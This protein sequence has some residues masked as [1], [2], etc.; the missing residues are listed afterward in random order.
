MPAMAL[1]V[2]VVASVGITCGSRQKAWWYYHQ[3]PTTRLTPLSTLKAIAKAPIQTTRTYTIHQ[4]SS[5]ANTVLCC[6]Q[7]Y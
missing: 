2:G 1:L 7:S 3:Q 5:N 4:V 6:I